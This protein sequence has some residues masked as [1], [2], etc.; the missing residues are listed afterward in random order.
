MDPSHVV[1]RARCA[2]CNKALDVECEGV[3]ASWGYQTY[4]EFLCPLC[5][6]RNV[7]LTPGAIVSA[8]APPPGVHAA[9]PAADQGATRQ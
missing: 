9:V 7:Q 5:R 4:N 3:S 1:L 8:A 6:K 2:H